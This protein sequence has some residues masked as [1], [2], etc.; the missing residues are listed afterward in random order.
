[1]NTNKKSISNLLVAVNKMVSKLT[2][3]EIKILESGR[4]E[5]SLRATKRSISREGKVSICEFDK[6]IVDVIN[7]EL[8]L[9]K[10]REEGLKIIDSHIKNRKELEVF[11][12]EI[13][14]AVRRSDKVDVIK[15]NIVDAT[16]GARIRSGAIQG[17]EI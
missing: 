4:F 14:V 2:D 6:S 9:A 17:K 11:A 1:M 12:K 3:E 13:D 16:V 15:D 5:I 7:K 10:S 8:D